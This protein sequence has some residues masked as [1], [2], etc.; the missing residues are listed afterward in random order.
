[1][2]SN[3]NVLY[4]AAGLPA[5]IS[6]GITFIYFFLK[7]C[8]YVF[9]AISHQTEGRV[10]MAMPGCG[11][12]EHSADTGK[13]GHMEICEQISGNFTEQYGGGTQRSPGSIS[14]SRRRQDLC[15]SSHGD[16]PEHTEESTFRENAKRLQGGRHRNSQDI[17]GKGPGDPCANPTGV[18]M[19][20]GSRDN[21]S[22]EQSSNDEGN[23]RKRNRAQPD[24]VFDDGVS[25]YRMSDPTHYTTTTKTKVTHVAL[26]TDSCDTLYVTKNTLTAYTIAIVQNAQALQYDQMYIALQMARNQASLETPL[27]AEELMSTHFNLAVLSNETDITKTPDAQKPEAN[28]LDAG[29]TAST[30][31]EETYDKIP[32][33]NHAANSDS[34]KQ[35]PTGAVTPTWRREY[36]LVNGI[37]AGYETD[38]SW[39][40]DSHTHERNHRHTHT[41]Y[42]SITSLTHL[43]QPPA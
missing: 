40:N 28:T 34:K 11:Q 26:Q 4:C 36:G 37:P 2:D 32:S 25:G 41:Q 42:S 20:R 39:D 10:A 21:A 29:P 18:F 43:E 14:L 12:Q 35:H 19:K 16:A 15:L 22:D 8:H 6:T 1:M 30:A 3:T 24:Q 23:G 5:L 33:R 31:N 27:R 7:A 13:E 38:D 17:N 9:H